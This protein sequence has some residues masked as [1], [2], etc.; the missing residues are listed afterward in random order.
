[1]EQVGTT[2]YRMITTVEYV[3]DSGLVA[4]YGIRCQNRHAPN[5]SD[6]AQSQDVPNIS[7]RPDF[8]EELIEKLRHHQADPVHL[9]DLIEDSLP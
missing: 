5:G 1:M 4:S 9:R 3:E 7:T 8:V 6:G 2:E